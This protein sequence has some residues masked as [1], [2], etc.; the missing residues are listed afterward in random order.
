MAKRDKIQLTRRDMLR[1]SAGGA[2]L[3]VLSASGLAVPRGF[4]SGGSGGGGSVYIEAFP[5]SP[6]ITSPFN[7]PLN[8]P[9]AMR[10]SDPTTWDSP[11]GKPDPKVQDSLGPSPT[12]DYE[13]KYGRV[14]GTHQ[15]WPG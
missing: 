14:L 12:K 13:N 2:G 8:I 11:G 6:L 4:G 9:S 7:D 5:T 10:P 1:L 15:F 3:F